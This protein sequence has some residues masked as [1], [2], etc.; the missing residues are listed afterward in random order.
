[1]TELEFYWHKDID[2]SVFTVSIEQSNDLERWTPLVHRATLADLQFGGQ[3][4]ER[5]IVDLPRQPLKYLKLTWQDSHWPL[6]LTAVTGFS[7][8]K[9]EQ[10]RYRW[11]SLYNGIVH[12]KDGQVNS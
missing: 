5:R 11:V 6:R 1:M 2:S 8:A 7:Q 4:V 12:E 3:Q 10:T 9:D